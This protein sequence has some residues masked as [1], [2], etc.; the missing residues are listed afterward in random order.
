MN[1][2]NLKGVDFST[3]IRTAVLIAALINQAL[4]VCGITKN[5]ADMDTL[6]YYISFAFT[7]ISSVWSWWKNNSFTKN[8]QKADET[9]ASS[10]EAKG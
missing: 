5:E 8:A 1:K 9:I 2:I 10:V 6:T 7:A 4:V 3:W